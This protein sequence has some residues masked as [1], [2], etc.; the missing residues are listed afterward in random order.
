MVD[1]ILRTPW[2]FCIFK[3]FVAYLALLSV[4]DRRPCEE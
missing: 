2:V 1:V 3:N 4:R